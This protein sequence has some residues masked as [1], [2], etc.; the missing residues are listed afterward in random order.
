MI[1]IFRKKAIHLCE[2]C[3]TGRE[4]YE[5]DSRSAIC[6]HLFHYE[7]DKCLYYIPIENCTKK[8]GLLK[9]LIS[10]IFR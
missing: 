1:K 2:N 5:L 9:K 10:C 4:T 7:N 8:N 6:P 3:K